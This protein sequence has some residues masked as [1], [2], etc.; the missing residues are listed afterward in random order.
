LVSLSPVVTI[1]ITVAKL[2]WWITP[3]YLCETKQCSKLAHTST[4]TLAGV[5]FDAIS[6]FFV[7]TVEGELA[8]KVFRPSF[9]PTSPCSPVQRVDTACKCF[10]ER[11]WHAMACP[12]YADIM[13]IGL[14]V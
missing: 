6:A 14:A 7:S 12:S 3:K 8:A 4:L 9:P 10:V 2:F 1:G 13:H 11:F 5:F